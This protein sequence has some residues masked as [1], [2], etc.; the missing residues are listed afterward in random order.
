METGKIGG[1]LK[2]GVSRVD[3]RMCPIEGCTSCPPDGLSC[4]EIGGVVSNSAMAKHMKKKHPPQP[5]RSQE[6]WQAFCQ[7]C[8]QA[9]QLPATAV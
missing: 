4:A 2:P 6:Q 5:K 7:K 8:L 1:H 3:M 9:P